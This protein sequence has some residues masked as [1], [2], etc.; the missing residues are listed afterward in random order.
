MGVLR[1]IPLEHILQP[2]LNLALRAGTRV[3]G[4][5]NRAESRI[6]ETLDGKKE[7]RMVREIE[8]LRSKLKAMPFIDLKKPRNT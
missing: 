3:N 5:L 7:V 8:D 2:E 4:T 1:S 6:R